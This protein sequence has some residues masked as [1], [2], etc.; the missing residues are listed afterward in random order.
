MW[1]KALRFSQLMYY[2]Q[3]TNFDSTLS[4]HDRNVLINRDRAGLP[5]A[6]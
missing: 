1:A 3:S 5:R 4:S 2:H 6:H